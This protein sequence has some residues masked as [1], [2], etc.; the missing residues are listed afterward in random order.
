MSMNLNSSGNSDTEELMLSKKKILVVD[1]E[2]D[3]LEFLSYNIKKRGGQSIYRFKW[4][5]SN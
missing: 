4:I 5:S 1:D 2:K 3:I